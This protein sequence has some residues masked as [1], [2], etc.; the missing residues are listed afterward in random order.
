MTERITS[1]RALLLGLLD[2]TLLSTVS[3][4]DLRPGLEEL[5]ANLHESGSKFPPSSL[6]LGRVVLHGLGHVVEVGHGL[7]LAAPTVFHQGH[8]G[9]QR[10][11]LRA[12]ALGQGDGGGR[13]GAGGEVLLVAIGRGHLFKDSSIEVES[14]SPFRASGFSSSVQI[15]IGE[16]S[17][18]TDRK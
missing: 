15:E 14:R 9:V 11:Q 17:E 6:Q 13:L 18:V 7:S 10:G 2:V 16:N 3:L 12:E 8:D 5:V 4:L 1:I